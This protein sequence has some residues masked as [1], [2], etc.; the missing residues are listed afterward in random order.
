MVPLS[1]WVR[2]TI[3]A[4]AV[5][6]FCFLARQSIYANTELDFFFVNPGVYLTSTELPN[7][8]P[9]WVF[10]VNGEHTSHP[11]FS[12]D[13]VMQ[14]MEMV[15]Y[16]QAEEKSNPDHAA[17]LIARS[18]FEK[19]YPEVNSVSE[20]DKLVWTPLNVNEQ[21][22]R[23]SATYRI[24]ERAYQSTEEL[25]IVN[26]GEVVTFENRMNSR[27][28]WQFDFMIKNQTG[29]ALVHCVD[30]RF[31]HD[32]RW[33]DG[34]P[35]F[36]G[37]KYSP[38]PRS[39]CKRCFG[40]GFEWFP[41]ENTSAIPPNNPTQPISGQPASKQKAVPSS[42]GAVEQQPPQALILNKNN[43][44][45]SKRAPNQ[46][47]SPEIKREDTTKYRAL[48]L[49]SE[50][51][52]WMQNERVKIPDF[53]P[54]LAELYR[55]YPQTFEPR[56]KEIARD[57]KRCGADT[58]KLEETIQSAN[59]TYRSITF[60]EGIAF[61]LHEAAFDIPGGQPQCGTK[62]VATS[63]FHEKDTG[64]YTLK[65][66]R[67][68]LGMTEDQ[69][70]TPHSP[71]QIFGL[72]LFKVYLLNDRFY[73]DTKLYAGYGIPSV[74]VVR[75]EVTMK[76][77]LLDRNFTD[78]ALEV[79]DQRGAP[80]LQMIFETDRQVRINGIFAT[81]DGRSAI[82]ITLTGNQKVDS[83]QTEKNKIIVPLKPI[84]KYP[85]WKYPGV[86]ADN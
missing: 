18:I 37:A 61:T 53:D 35:C 81:P 60:L 39:L 77:A 19:H 79:V 80:L 9:G 31:P 7:G 63:G 29:T 14:D 67:S 72:D 75:N 70:E 5:L 48:A 21:E 40:R 34:P 66:G 85:S 12:A 56:V 69:L 65:V 43:P 15:R 50:L 36:P 54:W 3:L 83:D 6:V 47:V 8:A 11:I 46:P 30:K 45:Q 28:V 86:Y 84:F 64:M 27:P 25:R 62:P 4:F 23:F 41:N 73:V 38:F 13:M 68:A 52:K 71:M 49:S 2:L 32:D 44:P 22:Y 57:L 17:T 78:K 24:G 74:E 10:L 55:Q 33:V 76:I 59:G 20:A 82:I 58:D 16:A 51:W 42:I 1:R 26:V